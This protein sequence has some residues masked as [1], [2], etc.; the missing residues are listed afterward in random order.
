MLDINKHSYIK[1]FVFASLYF[2]EGLLWSISTVVVIIY[3]SDKGIPDPIVTLAVG[4]IGLPWM[5][6]FIWGPITDFFIT[7]GRKRFIILGGTLAATL[8]FIVTFIDPIVALIPFTIILFIAHVAVGFLDVS[9]DAWAIEISTYEERGKINGGMFAG[10]F[11]GYAVGSSLFSYIAQNIGFS[12]VFTVAGILVFLIIIFP[13]LIKETK[14]HRKREKIASILLHEF[15]K[16]NTQLIAIHSLFLFINIGFLMCIIPLYML[17]V[18]HLEFFQIGLI[19]AIFPISMI[20]GSIVGGILT[21]LWGRKTVLYIFVTASII[22]T[23][24]FIF[25]DTWLMLAFVYGIIGFLHGAYNAASLALM[26]DVTNPKIGATQF[27]FLT[28]FANVGEIGI[29]NT[30]SGSLIALFGFSRAFL[31]SAWV[32]G[33]ALLLLYFVKTNKK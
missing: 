12:Y 19:S 10:L 24:A 5:L 15:K 2:S 8:F 21:D 28:A 11:I 27:S 9:A 18:L 25:A 30:C 16:R 1:Y 20:I 4:I 29:G 33:P 26:M 3:L 31:F 14:K 17:N 22:F 23:I 6:K 32:F 7:F 13:L